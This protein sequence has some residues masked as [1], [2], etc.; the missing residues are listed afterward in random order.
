MS[1]L[2]VVHVCDNIG[3]TKHQSESYLL[4]FCCCFYREIVD[5]RM[6]LM[7]SIPLYSIN[8]TMFGF[9]QGLTAMHLSKCGAGVKVIDTLS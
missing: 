8:P 5:A 1:F 7:L 3:Y 4:C 6:A 2:D 9:I